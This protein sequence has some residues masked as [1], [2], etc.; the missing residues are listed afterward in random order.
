VKVQKGA[1]FL[2]LT[3]NCRVPHKGSPAHTTDFLARN[4]LRHGKIYGYAVDM[5]DD[6][7]TGGMWRDE[8]HKD[9]AAMNGASVPGIWIAI[10]WAWNGTVTDYEH[11]GAWHFQIKPPGTTDGDEVYYW[12]AAGN[13]DSGNKME[14]VTPDPRPGMTGFLQGSTAGYFGH[15][16]VKDL[17]DVL[18]SGL[19]DMIE[20]EY[21]VYQGELDIR[22]QVEL[23][24]K[25]QYVADAEGNPR[26][27]TCNY[28]R[29]ANGCKATFEDIDGLEVICGD[30]DCCRVMIQEDSGND[31][32]ERCLISS[33]LEHDED[34]QELTYYF[35]AFSGG[36]ENTRIVNGVGIPKTSNEAVGS[37]EFSGVF[38]L[39]GLLRMENGEFTF[40]ASDPGYIKR[41]EEKKVNINEKDIMINVQASNMNDRI[42]VEFGA[43]TGGQ[44]MIYKPLLPDA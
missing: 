26:D 2:Q 8:F 43:D 7:P 23:G 24:G 9:P 12:N 35:V 16:Y 34:G 44:V 19:P 36:I 30:G 3:Y 42:M 10:D 28:D 4:G 37:H 5:S 21:Y 20:G 11:D 41:Q 6:G 39:S 13:D 32:G 29:A 27:A 1:W 33:C 31:L 15:Y 22:D 38:D 40:S 17:G 14:H 18:A 25:G